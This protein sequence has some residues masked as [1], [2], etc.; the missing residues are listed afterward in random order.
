MLVRLTTAAAA[1]LVMIC[2]PAWAQKEFSATLAGPAI[3]PPE[4]FIDAP[5]DLKVSG[6]YTTDKRIEAIGSVNGQVVRASDWRGAAVQGTTNSGTFGHQ[7]HARWHVLDHHRYRLRF[8]GQQPRLD[9][10]TSIAVGSIGQV[11]ACRDDFLHDPDKKVPFRIAHESTN[12]RYLTGAN[13]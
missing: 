2:T 6:K 4:T 5:A 1:A 11:A 3:L 13:F 10:S 12:K 8:K 9:G 7:G